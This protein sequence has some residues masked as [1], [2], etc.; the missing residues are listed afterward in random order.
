MVIAESS[1][2]GF[3]N[4]FIDALAITSAV[5]T[6]MHGIVL[7]SLHK[8]I[9]ACESAEQTELAGSGKIAGKSSHSGLPETW[10]EAGS[11]EDLRRKIAA[12][13]VI[14]RKESKSDFWTPRQKDDFEKA[15]AYV[16]AA[17]DVIRR[18]ISH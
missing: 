3:Y 5:F 4:S 17:E 16:D 15:A 12:G 10:F 13:S 6:L 18:A 9:A 2:A 1:V 14:L 8:R 7:R 11:A